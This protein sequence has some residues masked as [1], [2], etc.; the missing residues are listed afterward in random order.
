[1]LLPAV[2]QTQ[3]RLTGHIEDPSSVAIAGVAISLISLDRV[4]R[5]TSAPNGYFEFDNVSRGVCELV[6]SS[7]GF[8]KQKLSIAFSEET[9]SPIQI[10]LQVGNG[11]CGEPLSV[12]YGSPD[13]KSPHLAGII[14]GYRERPKAKAEVS[15]R[16]TGDGQP[17]FSST[18]SQQG[19][20]AFDEVPPGYYDL[21]IAQKGYWPIEIKRLIIPRENGV[22][23]DLGMAKRNMVIVCQ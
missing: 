10:T 23:V 21:R 9:A 11:G 15:L 19:K 6:V 22:F 12:E 1:M 7:P 14:R 16:R 18:P 20:F 3:S 2:G 5:T 13:P 8:A 17:V 4:I